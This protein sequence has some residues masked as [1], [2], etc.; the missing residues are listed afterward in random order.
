MSTTLSSSP[1]TVPPRID[2]NCPEQGTVR[3]AVTGEIDLSTAD[4]LRAALLGVLAA[5]RPRRIEVDLAEVTFLDCGGVT[6]LVVVGNAAARTGCQLRI[7]NPQP[8][9]RRVLDLTGLLDTLTARFA[10]I[11]LMP[12]GCAPAS[13]TGP[14]PDDRTPQTRLL[15]AA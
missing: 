13:P 3:V 14:A 4:L 10:R 5:Q 8:I 12:T 6:V 2:A 9:V 1:P 7:T 15:V 11:P